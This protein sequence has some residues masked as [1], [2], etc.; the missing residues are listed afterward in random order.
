M[1]R[2]VSVAFG[3]VI[4]ALAHLS[5]CGQPPCACCVCR[6]AG[7]QRSS[8]LA[9]GGQE[10]NPDPEKEPAVRWIL[11]DS[12]CIVG[13]RLLDSSFVDVNVGS[14]GCPEFSDLLLSSDALKKST[15]R[16]TSQP[17]SRPAD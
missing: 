7:G 10:R 5:G 6:L 1:D 14:P 9:D 3:V 11:L 17:A 15:Q 8:I 16:P 4:A 13:V 2:I 12:N